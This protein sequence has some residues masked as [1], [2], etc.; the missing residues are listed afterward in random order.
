MSIRK[1]FWSISSTQPEDAMFTIVV[2]SDKQL[3]KSGESI[4][5]FVYVN[6]KDTGEELSFSSLKLCLKES[7]S[8]PNALTNKKNVNSHMITQ[9]LLITSENDSYTDCL[10]VLN[11]SEALKVPFCM[12]LPDSLAS[13]FNS[14]DVAVCFE[15]KA[16][17]QEL[18]LC[19]ELCN[20]S[21]SLP[22]EIVEL[23]QVL[24]EEP[25]PT[26]QLQEAIDD[27][28]MTFYCS[29]TKKVFS[30]GESLLVE[31][32]LDLSG[33]PNV[34]MTFEIQQVWFLKGEKEKTTTVKIFSEIFTP[35]K[36]TGIL[37]SN[38]T[39]L[40][41]NT[42]FTTQPS[43]SKNMFVSMQYRVSVTASFWERN[44]EIF[45]PIVIQRN[46]GIYKRYPKVYSDEGFPL[47]PLTVTV[48]ELKTDGLQSYIPMKQCYENNRLTVK[49]GQIGGTSALLTIIS[50]SFKAY[51]REDIIKGFV[52]LSFPDIP[53]KIIFDKLLIVLVGVCQ[54]KSS[55]TL[56]KNG[57]MFLFKNKVL[58]GSKNNN[59]SP[60][61]LSKP[62][63]GIV[64]EFEFNLGSFN[65]A[66]PPSFNSDDIL[67]SYELKADVFNLMIG[68]KKASLY[69]RLPVVIKDDK[70][71]EKMS[72]P[73][74]LGRVC[75]RDFTISL[76]MDKPIYKHKD[77]ICLKVH[78]EN[79]SKKQ[80][81]ARVV[82]V[83]FIES[84]HTHKILKE[85]VVSH[86]ILLL[87]LPKSK[88]LSEEKISL[89]ENIFHFQPTL[90]TCSKLSVTY[91][92]I[93][94]IP[95]G[96]SKK[97]NRIAIP[98]P[99]TRKQGYE[100]KTLSSQG[101]PLLPLTL[102]YFCNDFTEVPEFLK[103]M[104]EKSLLKVM[105]SGSCL[106]KWKG[107]KLK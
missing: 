41:D 9:K 50:E 75:K 104:Y 73:K 5:G 20:L 46:D 29:L 21:T 99:I 2:E 19:G 49:K 52:Y 70:V 60:I 90:L 18:V 77:D 31:F 59:H 78:L 103:E 83:Q 106:E 72:I 91:S 45:I 58:Q 51:T 7:V 56:H 92:I 6:F 82:L 26:A 54:Y 97:N 14:P 105:N 34:V 101:Y 23:T 80:I 57:E 88:L 76:N 1:K 17:L 87:V 37:R 107:W 15:L 42:L 69:T 43:V 27:H 38:Y 30:A 40:L 25:S 74:S 64:V 89:K 35:A 4:N 48:Q 44:F 102:E 100:V 8:L 66:L 95:D 68:E 10:S 28:L 85:N 81:T 53:D 11:N 84:N 12:V 67:I 63:A 3:F 33:C 13:S 98:V 55:G 94:D 62:S 47:L 79:K 16:D 61:V 36:E 96:E 32:Y 71:H 93:V 65:K 22:I 86:P 24:N 39:F